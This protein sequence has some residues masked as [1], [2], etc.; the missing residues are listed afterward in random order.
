MVGVPAEHKLPRDD[1]VAL[2]FF[3]VSDAAALRDVDADPEHR[4]RFEFL[5]DFVPSLEHSERVIS[6]WTRARSGGGPFVFAVRAVADG[7]LLGGCEIRLLE[8]HV[9]NLSYFTL[10]RHRARGV[11]SRAVALA[12]Q[13]AIAPLGVQRLEIVVDPDNVPSR[14]VAMR[15]GFQEAGMRHGRIL[16]VRDSSVPGTDPPNEAIHATCED[17]RA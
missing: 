13:V 12:C 11:A 2:T 7:E 1:S 16:Y 17:A 15:N 14:R 8:H 10:P 3:R 4:R 9:A 5:E 6:D